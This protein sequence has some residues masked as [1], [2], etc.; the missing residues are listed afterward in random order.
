MSMNIKRQSLNFSITDSDNL[1]TTNNDTV[2]EIPTDKIIEIDKQDFKI[3][4]DTVDRIAESIKING[5]LEPCVVTPHSKEGY[6]ELLAGRHRKRACEKAGLE[7]AKCIIKQHLSDEDK[8]LII[9]D[10]NTERNNDYDPSEL[11]FAFRH[12]YEILSKRTNKAIKQIADEGNLTRKKVYRYIRLT[13]LIKP[14]LNR[15]DSGNIPI[16]AAVELSY[17]NEKQQNDI[18]TYLIN[19]ATECRITTDN[20][21]LLKLY[22]A[23][24]ADILSGNF[25][26]DENIFFSD[27]FGKKV[28]STIEDN[29]AKDATPNEVPVPNHMIPTEEKTTISKP[30]KSS[31]TKKV[32][33]LSKLSIKDKTYKVTLSLTADEITRLGLTG[34]CSSA[35]IENAIR[36][37]IN[38]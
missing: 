13:Y 25:N 33:N 17:L 2:V 1:S 22:P 16:I 23:D 19:H 10:S 35:E 27:D 21:K 36:A 4:Q 9:I 7:N 38:I 30:V 31:D 8:E 6:Y 12:K 11:A 32:D 5:Q 15:V 34:D 3:H 37:L 29:N 18:F 26:P 14:L 28:V 24:Y 20:A